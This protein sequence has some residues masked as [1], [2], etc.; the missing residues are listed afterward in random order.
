[1][2]FLAVY[3]LDIEASLS[4]SSSHAVI[5][6]EKIKK[7]MSSFILA[8]QREETRMSS[9]GSIKARCPEGCH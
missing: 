9:L 1:M 6:A 5:V 8:F 2:G 4:L 3:Y 7:P